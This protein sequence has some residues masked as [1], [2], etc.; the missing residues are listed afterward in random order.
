MKPIKKKCLYIIAAIV[1][2]LCAYGQDKNQLYLP[3]EY[4]NAYKNETRSWD[5]KPGKNYFQNTTDYSIKAEF[6]PELKRLTGKEII[7]YK[8]NSPDKQHRHRRQG[9]HKNQL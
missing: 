3:N 1:I 8:N 6:L 5:G 7:H 9:R 4:R 2:S